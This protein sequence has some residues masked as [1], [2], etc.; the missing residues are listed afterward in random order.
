MPKKPLFPLLLG[1]A[2]FF[3]HALYAAL[4]AADEAII[5]KCQ[6]NVAPA[7]GPL[8]PQVAMECVSQLNANGGALLNALKSGNQEEAVELISYNNALVDLANITTRYSGYTLAQA[9]GRELENKPCALCDMGLGPR[10]ER[11]FDWIS[12]NA[13]GRLNVVKRSVRTWDTLGPIRTEALAAE[14]EGY[15]KD[16][17]NKIKI[18]KRYQRLSNWARARTDKL[19]LDNETAMSDLT[20]IL[21]EDLILPGDD[22]YR[23][24]L[25][26][27]GSAR[28]ASEKKSLDRITRAGR[29]AAGLKDQ[30]TSGQKD[31]L[32]TTFDR[33]ATGGGDTGVPGVSERT[34]T[35]VPIDNKQAREL[36][37]RMGTVTDG[38][39]T[40]Y[41]ADEMKGTKAGDELTAFFTDKNYAAKGTNTLKLK[42][43]K[44][45]GATANALGWWDSSNKTTS[46]NTSLVDDYCLE[47][48]ITPEQMLASEEHL[49]GVARYITPNFVHETVHQ[50]QDAWALANGLDYIKYRDG[51]TGQPYQMEMETESFSMQAAFSSEKARQLGPTYLEQ[52][53]PSHKN[54]AIR[55]M[56]D[57]VDALR[58]GKHQLYPSISSLEGSTAREFRMA[59]DSAKYLRLLEEKNRLTPGEMTLRDSDDLLEYRAL[60]D[61]R[62]K[63]YSMVY[64]K[65]AADERKLLEWRDSF[66]DS[67]GTP[68]PALGSGG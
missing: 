31:Y 52:I 11:T 13:S 3:P 1:A 58:T 20:Y 34:F 4:S 12:V 64:Q 17:W 44:G 57:G 55:F 43:E 33:A 35:P 68:P 66:S 14:P 67:G 7:K 62:F 36:S 54:N 5:T 26:D 10:P 56:E 46:V 37:T 32:D 51:S 6:D 47:H 59:R 60:L 2:L 8:S 21:I 48:R 16:S 65:S 25:T 19:V 42:F 23:G 61:T 63:W 39:F 50:R 53:S 22:E 15:T 29:T 45:E 27:L 28:A 41:L 38:K 9:L 18:P 40:G 30:S 24:K 49:R